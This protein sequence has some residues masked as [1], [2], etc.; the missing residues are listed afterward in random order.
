MKIPSLPEH[1]F[2]VR[3]KAARLF[4]VPA[5]LRHRRRA[6]RRSK[7]PQAAP[8]PRAAFPLGKASMA[9]SHLLTVVSTVAPYGQAE[10]KGTVRWEHEFSTDSRPS[11]TGGLQDFFI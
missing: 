1:L 9:R 11:T 10:T 2:F 4:F 5:C 3:L 6:Q 7:A 8:Q